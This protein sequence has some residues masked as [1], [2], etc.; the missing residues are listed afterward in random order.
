MKQKK[1]T[2]KEL[3]EEKIAIE[4][5]AKVLYGGTPMSEF[6]G[7]MHRVREERRLN[8]AENQDL[9][10]EI[11]RYKQKKPNQK[12]ASGLN[13]GLP[14]VLSAI[15]GAAIG[16]ALVQTGAVEPN[17]MASDMNDV[18]GFTMASMAAGGVTGLIN[19]IC[20]CTKPITRAIYDRQI[21]KRQRK[22]DANN[23][24]NNAITYLEECLKKEEASHLAEFTDTT[25]DNEDTTTA[26]PVRRV[27]VPGQME[28]DDMDDEDTYI[29]HA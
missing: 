26:K 9:A 13:T 8:W 7:Y 2:N 28:I 21:A 5:Q 17:F 20:Y 29:G 10:D 15:A 6:N 14:V 19:S 12:E 23:R 18:L 27:E 16:N 25:L 22:L 11:K 24:R 4:R 1:P 3:E